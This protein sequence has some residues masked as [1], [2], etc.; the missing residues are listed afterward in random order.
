M[1]V[2]NDVLANRELLNAEFAPTKRKKSLPQQQYNKK[3]PLLEESPTVLYWA[4]RKG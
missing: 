1:H 3:Q 4:Q 2:V